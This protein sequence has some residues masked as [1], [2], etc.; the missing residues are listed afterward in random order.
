MKGLGGGRSVCRGSG[1][2]E[3]NEKE[4]P[5]NSG[6]MEPNEEYASKMK[7]LNKSQVMF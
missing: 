1:E 4:K 3:R 5:R 6:V 7:Q 2:A